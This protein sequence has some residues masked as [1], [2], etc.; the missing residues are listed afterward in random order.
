MPKVNIFG[1]REELSRSMSGFSSFAV[2]F[3]LI[4]VLTG[5]F[6]NF[7]FGYQQAGGAIVWT[8]LL[9]ACGQ[10]LVALVMAN[11]SIQYPIAGYGYQWA[12]RLTRTD[13]GYFVGWLLLIQFITGFPGICQTFTATLMGLAGVTG[14][15]DW[16]VGGTIVVISLVA[17]IHWLGIRF[18]SK[19]NDAGVFAELAGVM[20]LIFILAAVWILNSDRHLE[21]ITFIEQAS[22]GF[23]LPF[24]S[25]ALSMLL[26][27]WCLT[28]FE[29]AADLAEETRS[30]V[31]SVPRAVMMSQVT[32]ALSGLL[33]IILLILHA[34]AVQG[35]Q[36]NLLLNIL[37][38]TLGAKM[39]L[40]VI[41][42][43]LISIF[44]CAVASMA[45]MSR[46]LFSM[47]RDRILPYS[48]WIAR[49]DAGSQSPRQAIILIWGLSIGIILLFRKIE[50][51]TNV[52]ALATYIGYAGIMLAALM[53]KRAPD[54][55]PYLYARRW[56]RPIQ[57]IAFIWTLVVVAALSFPETVIEGY[58]TK[59][60]P[61][62]ATGIACF[63]GVLLYFFYVRGKIRSGSAGPPRL[64]TV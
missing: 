41:L 60:L 16:I 10:F 13:F 7:N 61:A 32:S 20:F 1:Y 50:V 4:S 22:K 47:S 56:E 55:S 54:I 24:S 12:A 58:E 19:V 38:Q 43:I 48:S 59:H 37:Q 33:I 36:G 28:G 5:L 21:K 51:V 45:T 34:G 17:L 15:N 23:P 39:T 2:S 63:L 8:W 27:A 57:W 6:A 42:F 40:V 25:L 26:G 64:P 14:N 31:T 52:S 35:Q 9:V 29:A 11:L 18:A 30:P 49:V 44:A 46:L 62:I 3:S 53:G